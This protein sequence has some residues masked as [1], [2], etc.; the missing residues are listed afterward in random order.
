MPV[1]G[2][3]YGDGVTSTIAYDVRITAQP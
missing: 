3:F 1:E 2:G